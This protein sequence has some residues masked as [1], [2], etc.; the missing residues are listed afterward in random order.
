MGTILELKVSLNILGTIKVNAEDA[1]FP[2]RKIY[3]F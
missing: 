2:Q 3:Y 1:A